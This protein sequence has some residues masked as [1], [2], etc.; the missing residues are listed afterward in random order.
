MAEPD[1][2]LLGSELVE[3][4]IRPDSVGFVFVSGGYWVLEICVDF[5]LRKGG[6]TIATIDP[7]E[8]DDLSVLRKLIGTS[9]SQVNW[10]EMPPAV[11]ISIVLSDQT[12]IEIPNLRSHQFSRGTLVGPNSIWEEF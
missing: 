11:P 9:V 10:P 3:L 5:Y 1:D 12:V 8:L 6:R 7:I 4:R 2:P